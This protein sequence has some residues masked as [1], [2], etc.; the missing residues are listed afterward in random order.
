MTLSDFVW[1]AIGETLLAGTFALGILVGATLSRKGQRNGDSDTGTES[2]GDHAGNVNA[3]G[4]TS[5]RDASRAGQE[6]Q[7]GAAKRPTW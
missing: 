4:R 7:A 6:R 5:G 2:N 3:E 1:L